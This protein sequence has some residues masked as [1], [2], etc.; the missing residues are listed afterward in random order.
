MEMGHCDSSVEWASNCHKQPNVSH[1]SHQSQASALDHTKNECIDIV[2]GAIA[3]NAVGKITFDDQVNITKPII[4][5]STDLE[6]PYSS[7]D[8]SKLKTNFLP[9]FADINSLSIKSTV[10]VI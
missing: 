1:D 4:L 3:A 8:F 9:V 2:T 7:F 6:H 5:K 10:L